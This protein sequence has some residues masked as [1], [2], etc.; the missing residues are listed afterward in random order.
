MIRVV[1]VDD[2]VI[3]RAGLE[4]VLA[5]TDDLVLVSTASDGEDAA[6]Q[7]ATTSP[8]PYGSARLLVPC[9]DTD[10]HIVRPVLRHRGGRR[11]WPDRSRQ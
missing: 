1:V 5:A 11:P 2:H 9:P 3:V 10:P 4:Q 7:L 8:A 6:A